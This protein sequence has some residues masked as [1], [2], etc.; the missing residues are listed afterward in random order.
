MSQAKQAVKVVI[1]GEEFSVRSE[2]PWAVTINVGVLTSAMSCATA[3]PF[4]SS[5]LRTVG[6]W[7]RSPRMVMGPVSAC[8]SASAIASRTPKHMPKWDARR[9][10]I[11]CNIKYP[12]T[13]TLSRRDYRN[14]STSIRLLPALSTME[15]TSERS[16]GDSATPY[17]NGLSRRAS[18]DL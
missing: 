2:V 11:L 5:A 18:V 10:R 1:G 15:N 3:I 7:T 13:H 8:S 17:Q 9:I 12:A 14:L 16:P 6:L 4:A